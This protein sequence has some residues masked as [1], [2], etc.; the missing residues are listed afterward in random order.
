VCDIHLKAS[1]EA[2]VQNDTQ[3][4]LLLS[5]AQCCDDDADAKTLM[6]LIQ[7]RDIGRG[8]AGISI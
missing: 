7:L 6:L 4:I 1:L 5:D 8:S 3:D 2:L